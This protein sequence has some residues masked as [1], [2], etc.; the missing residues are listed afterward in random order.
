MAVTHKNSR[1][2]RKKQRRGFT[3]IELGIVIAIIAVLA[4]VVIM[5]KG[6]L[7]GARAAKLIEA[8]DVIKKSVTTVAGLS[9]GLAPNTGVGSNQIPNLRAR[10][11]VPGNPVG[12]PAA[13][14]NAWV[15][16]GAEYAITDVRHG[17][18]ANQSIVQVQYRTPS[19]QFTAD[20]FEMARQE[21][22]FYI[23]ALTGGLPCA[24]AAPST[25]SAVI[26][27]AL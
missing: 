8:T 6:F 11:M 13:D 10:N 18:A 9:G 19:T 3:L 7:D 12:T 15:V 20:V 16:A 17:T 21:K 26:C 14:A 25:P 23:G 27:F 22:N 2:L 1:K 5:G 24:N 4:S